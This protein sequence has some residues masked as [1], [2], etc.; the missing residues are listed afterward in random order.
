MKR[1]KF[2]LGSLFVMLLSSLVLSVQANPDQWWLSAVDPSGV[3]IIIDRTVPVTTNW[4]CLHSEPVGSI[5]TIIHLT[6]WVDTNGDGQLSASD[7][8]Y[9]SDGSVWHV[10]RVMVT[11]HFTWKEPFPPIDPLDPPATD[12]DPT[13]DPP[14]EEDLPPPIGSKWH[15]IYPV[16]CL[17]FTI[18][19]WEDSDGGGTFNP[20]DQ[21]D[22]EF[23]DPGIGGPWWAH[24]D[25]VS[26]DIKLTM[27]YPNPQVP[28]FPLGLGAAM[29]LGLTVA[30]AYMIRKRK[31]AISPA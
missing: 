3:P 25:A 13:E 22:V 18:T 15:M 16:F 6:Q 1:N 7:Q 2:L 28:E 29:G 27:K 10:D 31:P 11:I 20:S 8:V 12:P 30:V 4:K 24:L 23:D 9:F 21:F 19:S 17:D 26:T 14:I 5:G